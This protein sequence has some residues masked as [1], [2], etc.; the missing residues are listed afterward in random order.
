MMPPELH[1][2][3]RV[4][5]IPEMGVEVVVEAG[6]TE[7]TALAARMRLPAI[8]ALRARF[9]LTLDDGG[10]VAATGRLEASVV[11]TCV[12]S[13]DDFDADLMEDF[14][15]RFVPEG[16]ESDDPDPE[17]VDEIPYGGDTIDLGEA[18]AEQLA[19]ALD[20]YPRRP[21][22][23]LPEAEAATDPRLA[24]LAAWRGAKGRS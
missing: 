24:A 19:L 9:A 18:T 15:V 17:S 16:T 8:P 21:D 7:R 11:Q 5:R 20:P 3:V 13:L 6:E 22:A 12:V 4:S 10:V 14:A 2:P 23:T 1:R